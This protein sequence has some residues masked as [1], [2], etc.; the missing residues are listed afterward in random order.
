MDLIIIKV[1]QAFT[2]MAN[3]NIQCCI[4]QIALS[5][6]S[7][8]LGKII[9]FSWHKNSPFL[10]TPKENWIYMHNQITLFGKNNCL[11]IVSKQLES[12]DQ[13]DN[14]AYW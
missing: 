6:T 10:K 11:K 8:Q 9:F 5:K 4:V 2:Y 14:D 1:S 7:F 13:L 3:W 12:V